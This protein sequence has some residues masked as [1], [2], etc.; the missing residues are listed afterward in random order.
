M[1]QAKPHSDDSCC[2]EG[3]SPCVKNCILDEYGYCA[4]CYRTM[5]EIM[6]WPEMRETERQAVMV[7]IEQRI[8][9]RSA[10][11]ASTKE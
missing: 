6:A 2:I 3:E 1:G 5:D 4:G 8:A 11:T 10:K 9:A 7:R